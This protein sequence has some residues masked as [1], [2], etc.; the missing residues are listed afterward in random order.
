MHLRAM[1]VVAWILLLMYFIGDLKANVKACWT[2]YIDLFVNLSKHCAGHPILKSNDKL[3]LIA[4]Y[5]V[6]WDR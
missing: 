6:M 4:W 3:L 5:C 2:L 1:C